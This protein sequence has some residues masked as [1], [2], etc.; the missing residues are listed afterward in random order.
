MNARSDPA[1]LRISL[2]Q[3]STGVR[4]L[5]NAILSAFFV[6]VGICPVQA[7]DTANAGEITADIEAGETSYQAVC[8]NCHGPKAQG[9]ASYPRLSDKDVAYLTDRLER[10]REGEKIGPNSMLMIPHARD[11]SDQEIANITAYVTTAFQ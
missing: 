2:A 9:I 3:L 6:F 10:Y 11:L 4:V 1:R 5:R 8:R 7:D